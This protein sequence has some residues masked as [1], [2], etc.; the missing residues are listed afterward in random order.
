MQNLPPGVQG[1]GDDC[2]I[3]PLHN[4]KVQVITTD[5]LIENR[6][7]LLNRISPWQLGY[8]SLAVNLSDIAAMG[9]K[10]K[11]AFLSIGVPAN[12]DLE[13]LEQFFNGMEALALE[14]GTLIL[15]GDTTGSEKLVINL[16]VLGEVEENKVKLRSK[17]RTGDL[18]CLTGM[19]GDS[20][21]GLKFLLEENLNEPVADHFI[22][23]HH[24]PRPHLEEG[25]FLSKFPGVT[26]MM[27]VSDGIESDIQRIME[28]SVVGALIELEELPISPELQSVAAR[29]GWDPIQ[30]ALCGG[31]DY[32]L[33]CT[34]DPK[35]FPEIASVFQRQFQQPLYRVGKIQ[36][37]Q[38]LQF[39]QAG[40]IRTISKTGFDHFRKS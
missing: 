23:Q 4:G 6:H 14:S 27:D 5:L 39:I 12:T 24:Q 8:K 20:G 15:G 29:H 26:G 7:F 40:N 18:I 19:V 38:K 32:C 3:I 16:C 13:W 35:N 34:I 21:T 10:P 17:A 30:L 36:A 22:K 28:S 37:E 9:A 33:L 31:E 25:L 11:S 2:A 1:I